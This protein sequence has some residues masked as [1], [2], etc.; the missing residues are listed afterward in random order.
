MTFTYDIYHNELEINTVRKKNEKQACHTVG[1]DP[2]YF[3]S[4]NG[5][6]RGEIDSPETQIHLNILILG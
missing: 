1:T 4:R 6:N 5:R 3:Q 2:I